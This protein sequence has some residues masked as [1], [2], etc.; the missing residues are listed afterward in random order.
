MGFL[1]GLQRPILQKPHNTISSIQ[2]LLAKSLR[3]CTFLVTLLPIEGLQSV[4]KH[5]CDYLHSLAATAIFLTCMPG[6]CTRFLHL[7]VLIQSL[8]D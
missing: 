4:I 5:C 8:T 1:W 6:P 7:D 2:N 3:G